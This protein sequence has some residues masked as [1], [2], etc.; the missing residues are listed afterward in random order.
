MRAVLA[1]VLLLAV[2]TGC[3]T[4]TGAGG[5]FADRATDF[6]AC[7]RCSGGPALGLH[8]RG[9]FLFLNDGFGFAYGR[10]YGWPRFCRRSPRSSPSIWRALLSHGH[11]TSAAP[12]SCRSFSFCA[13]TCASTRGWSRWRPWTRAALPERRAGVS[14]MGF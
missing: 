7:F 3:V 14:C 1:A 5:Y 11:S 2:L 4:P 12:A 10:S 9:R 6:T 8:V 13:S